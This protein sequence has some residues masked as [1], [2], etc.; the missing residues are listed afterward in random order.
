MKR[1]FIILSVIVL[2]TITSSAQRV[3]FNDDWNFLNSDIQGAETV[4][5]ND[6]GWRNL[7]LPHDWAI[8]GDFDIKHN[9]R[10]GGLP[11]NGTG[12]YRK[13]FKMLASDKGKSINILFDGAMN[14]AHVWVNGK[15][16]GN[17]PYGYASFHFDI[18]SYLNYG[19]TE[20]VIA[21]R[22]Q[23]E[24][25]SSRWYPGAGIY[26]N[27]WLYIDNSVHIPIWGTS[28]TTP[29][30]TKDLAVVEA[31]TKIQNDSKKSQTAV[32]K[33]SILNSNNEI[34]VSKSSAGVE[35][36][37]GE[38]AD[39]GVYMNIKNPE[40]WGVNN[41]YLHLLK[42]EVYVDDKL[43]DETITK[44]G[45]RSISYDTKGFYLNGE[46]LRFN[47]VCLHHDNGPLGGAFN[48]RADE[49]KL[50]IM[51]EM[52]VNAI[53]TSHNPPAPEFLDLCDSLG[54]LVINE[55]FDGWKMNKTEKDYGLHF[56]KW[57]AKDLEDIIL[58]DRNHPS[59]IMW[60]IGNE[61]LEQIEE[62]SQGWLI[63]KELAAITRMT[64][65][66]RPSTIGFN[67]Y[68][69]PFK[70]NLSSQVDIVGINYNPST[71]KWVS[72][73]YPQLVIYG[74]ETSSC[75][76]SRGIYH[77][78]IEKYAK[79]PSKQ[80]TSYDL[81]APA[82][83]YP[84][85][86]QFHFLEK[87]PNA[88]GEFIWTGFDYLGEP[89]PYGGSD[90]YTNGYW[91]DDWPSRSSYFGAVDLI[92]LKKDRFYLYQSQWT[93]EPMVHL[94]P[95]WNWEGME[96]EIIPVYAYTNCDEAEL[97]LNGVSLGKRVK[98]VDLTEIKVRFN[99]YADTLFQSPYRLSWKV[100]YKKGELKVVA[101]KDGK[102]CKEE[103]I[104][105][106]GK[107]HSIRLE[108]DRESISADGKDLVY[109]TATIIDKNGNVCPNADNLV[110]FNIEGKGKV[111][112]TGN[113]DATSTARFQV[114]YRHAFSGK[115]VGIIQSL[116]GKEGKIKIVAKSRGLKSSQIELT[117]NF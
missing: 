91:N 105:T 35:I 51:I 107:P 98:G 38:S 48:R 93:E 82:W 71:Y 31:I 100:P 44:F 86:M 7:N 66:T 13:S 89:T 109:A 45:I 61:I 57:G 90:N 18:S 4:D 73:K 27:V 108:I 77:L 55:I 50:E 74:S 101:Y 36:M 103:I 14:D 23:P 65:P 95:H 96:G 19:E 26:R 85:D 78:P 111:I 1:I 106:A 16:V 67:Y 10:T 92:G 21:V 42:S 30:V 52:G 2:C 87:N 114:N 37:A 113:G 117:S 112:A 70:H 40:L 32:V 115:C 58:R 64:D 60:S 83:A 9:A 97:F 8:E 6:S 84:P 62:K 99:N 5:F 59:I 79:H 34:L 24:D 17:R 116:K 39:A 75:T 29:T 3:S 80:V 22:L 47:G 76:S 72:E 53:R 25:L 94:L 54:L 43:V 33:Y 49:R 20:N 102:I 15:F 11:V 56:D 81:I 110:T 41:P 12:W 63:A 69:Q 46:K 88:L 28:I 104:N 68:P